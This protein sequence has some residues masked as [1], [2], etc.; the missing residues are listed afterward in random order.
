VVDDAC[1]AASARGIAAMISASAV[2]AK[3]LIRAL[4]IDAYSTA[5]LGREIVRKD[6]GANGAAPRCKAGPSQQ[7]AAASTQR[8]IE[9]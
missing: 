8:R 5:V 3:M 4:R 9:S 1:G 2:P 6:E 7:S